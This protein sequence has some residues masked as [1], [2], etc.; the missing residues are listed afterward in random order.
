MTLELAKPFFS[1]LSFIP[2]LSFYTWN[3][4]AT[5]SPQWLQISALF[6]KLQYLSIFILASTLNDLWIFELPPSKLV[7]TILLGLQIYT[8]RSHH[9]TSYSSVTIAPNAFKYKVFQSHIPSPSTFHRP[10][11]ETGFS[12]WSSIP[13]FSLLTPENW[14]ECIIYFLHNIT[15]PHWSSSAFSI[16]IDVQVIIRNCVSET[17]AFEGIP[18]QTTLIYP[19]NL[20]EAGP[21]SSSSLNTEMAFQIWHTFPQWYH[22]FT[23]CPRSHICLPISSTTSSENQML[24]SMSFHP[25]YD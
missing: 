25:S 2:S 14:P 1:T 16:K 11:L 3:F 21:V 15:L 22:P 20:I 18:L 7:F 12:G 13:F 4:K 6:Q 23:K 24:L 8:H 10:C 17:R 9:G 5:F 19:E